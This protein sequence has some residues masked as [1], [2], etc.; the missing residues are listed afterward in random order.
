MVI[1]A[2]QDWIIT[3]IIKQ[4]TVE[5]LS[6]F[7]PAGAFVQACIMIY[8]SVMF[9]IE[10]A[11]QIM[12]FGEAVINSVSAIASGAIGGAAAWIE[13]S[14]ANAIPVVIGFL[15]ALIGLGGISKKIRET[16]EKIQGVVDKAIDKAIEIGRAHV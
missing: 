3:T 11:G 9:L 7:N 16:I 14:L 8:N 1:G 4:A 12:A 13:R 6:M 5:L 2:I 15:A 10:R